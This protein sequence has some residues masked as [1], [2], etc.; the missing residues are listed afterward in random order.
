MNENKFVLEFIFLKEVNFI[1]LLERA[2]G[3][4]G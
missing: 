1:A 4:G 3:G 2:G